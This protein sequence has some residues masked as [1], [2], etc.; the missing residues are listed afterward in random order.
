MASGLESS[1]L[2]N[3]GVVIG[4]QLA[5][6]AAVDVLIRR[7]GEVLFAEPTFRLGVRSDGLGQRDCKASLFAGQYLLSVEVATV[8]DR[9]EFVHFEHFFGF[10][11]HPSKLPTVV[12]DVYDLMRNNQMVFGVH[13]DLDIVA[14][15]TRPLVAIER[16][17][18]SVSDIC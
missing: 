3:V 12:A 9:L 4:Q 17:S 11:R 2:W 13:R 16:A 5:G 15:D 18:G 8:G 7:V 6:R 10:L 1:R 14:D